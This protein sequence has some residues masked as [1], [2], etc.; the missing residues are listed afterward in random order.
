MKIRVRNNMS[1]PAII[2]IG[3]IYTPASSWRLPGSDLSGH[4]GNSIT[5]GF[6]LFSMDIYWGRTK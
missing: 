5:L 6:I 4:M 3:I 1:D 2:H